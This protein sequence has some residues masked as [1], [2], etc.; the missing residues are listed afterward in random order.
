MEKF[1]PLRKGMEIVLKQRDIVLKLNKV[2]C[3]WINIHKELVTALGNETC[4]LDQ[5]GHYK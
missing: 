1:S 5:M 4:I 3:F 2:K